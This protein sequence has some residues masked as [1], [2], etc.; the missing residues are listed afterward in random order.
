MVN[1]MFY[2]SFNKEQ[3]AM[4]KAISEEVKEL[5][6]KRRLSYK[7]AVAVLDIAQEKIKE[8]KITSEY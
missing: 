2:A 8:C 5:I 6:I 3:Q 7:E 4:L 1:Q